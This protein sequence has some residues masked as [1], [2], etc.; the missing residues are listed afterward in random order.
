MRV[1][2][3]KMHGCSN[4]ARIYE[5]KTLGLRQIFKK[6]LT[7]FCG[8]DEKGRVVTCTLP[9]FLSF[10]HAKNTINIFFP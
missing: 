7:G 4:A 3:R 8:K 5:Q 6:A 9:T 10:K 2:E 1:L